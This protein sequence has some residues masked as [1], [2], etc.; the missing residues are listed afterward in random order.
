MLKNTL[1]NF[2]ISIYDND[3]KVVLEDI[4]ESK[5]GRENLLYAYRNN[6]FASLTS[7]LKSIYTTTCNLVDERF[8]NYVASEYIKINPSKSGNLEDY[9]RNF[10]NFLKNLKEA[11]HLEYLPDLAKFEWLKHVC[12]QSRNINHVSKIS[13]LKTLY[14]DFKTLY[15]DT[16]PSLFLLRSKWPVY[17]IWEMGQ[18]SYNGNYQIDNNSDYSNIIIVRPKLEIKVYILQKEE[19]EFLKTIKKGKSIYQ[20]NK[21]A[22]K[23]NKNFIAHRAINKYIKES[24]FISVKECK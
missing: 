5:I 4:K 18:E 23:I 9:G 7:I 16:H 1:E 12:Y 3:N 19:Y 11:K 14:K 22:L 24:I 10:P 6:V 15:I 2:L 13:F 21:N 17:Q 8:F 20:A